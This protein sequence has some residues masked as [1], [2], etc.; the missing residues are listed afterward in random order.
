[1]FTQALIYFLGKIFHSS[2]P[3]YLL[4]PELKSKKYELDLYF[5]LNKISSHVLYIFVSR[6]GFLFLPFFLSFFIAVAYYKVA[7]S[8]PDGVIGMFH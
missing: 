3:T 1:M 2:S 5:L 8:I 6:F 4:L 7:G